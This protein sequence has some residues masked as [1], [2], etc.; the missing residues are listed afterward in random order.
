MADY[1]LIDLLAELGY[2]TND[3]HVNWELGALLRN[4]YRDQYGVLPP[5]QL[6]VKT[7]GTGSHCFA[8]YPPEF[9]DHAVS[10]IRYR[11]RM[12]ASQIDMFGSE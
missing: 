5:K 10:A 6:D 3:K 1:T 12:H 2:P 11:L 7:I 8:K 9:K 4:E